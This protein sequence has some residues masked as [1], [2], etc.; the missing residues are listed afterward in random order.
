MWL[1]SL[2]PYHKTW[3]FLIVENT[4]AKHKSHISSYKKDSKGAHS[5]DNKSELMLCNRIKVNPNRRENN[6][7][8]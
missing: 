8:L 5:P 7:K 4:E 3:I 2:A 6:K 1:A